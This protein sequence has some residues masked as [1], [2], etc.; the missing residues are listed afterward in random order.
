VVADAKRIVLLLAFSQTYPNQTIPYV[1]GRAENSALD[2]WACFINGFMTSSA[3]LQVNV[4][5]NG[6]PWTQETA[7]GTGKWAARDGSGVQKSVEVS[8]RYFSYSSNYVSG[9]ALLAP[10][11]LGD[12]LMPCSLLAC[13]FGASPSTHSPRFVVPAI[14]TLMQH[15]PDSLAIGLEKIGVSGNGFLFC[16]QSGGLTSSGLAKTCFLVSLGRDGKW[17]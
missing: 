7:A 2:P 12:S 15:V 9:N 17:D 8:H 6:L 5:I 14:R 13:T 11:T 3:A 4:G 16:R 10:A 1:F